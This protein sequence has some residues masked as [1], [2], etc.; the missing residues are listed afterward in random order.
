MTAAIMHLFD[1]P[2][3]HD[4]PIHRPILSVQWHVAQLR[5]VWKK[6]PIHECASVQRTVF[7]QF[8]QLF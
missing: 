8:T 3:K 6:N 5:V 7:A 1:Q 4:R 2:G